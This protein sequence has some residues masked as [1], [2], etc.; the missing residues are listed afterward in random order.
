MRFLGKNLHIWAAE[1]ASLAI[2]LYSAQWLQSDYPANFVVIH[3]GEKVL[4]S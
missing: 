1:L 4:K 3:D 2:A